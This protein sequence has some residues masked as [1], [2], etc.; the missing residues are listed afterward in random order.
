[1][2]DAIPI[3]RRPPVVPISD[4]LPA[5]LVRNLRTNPW[6]LRT[7]G[8][9]RQRQLHA[10]YDARRES[11][12]RAAD[13]AGLVYREADVA[14]RVAERLAARGCRPAARAAG[15]VHTLAFVPNLGWHFHLL[16][17]LRELGPVSLFDYTALG[18]TWTEFVRA[19]RHAIQRRARMNEQFLEYAQRVHAERPIDWLYVYASGLEVSASVIRRIGEELGVPTVS[20]CLDDKHAWAGPSMGDH[21]AGQIDIA[22]AFDLAWTSARVACEWYLVEGGNPIYLP[23]GFDAAA[24]HPMPV[25]VDLPASFVGTAYGFRPKVADYVRARGIPLRVFGAGWPYGEFARDPVEIFNRSVIN[26]GIGEAGYSE[27]LTNV[28]GRDFEIPGTGGGAYLTSYNADLAQ[29][30]VVGREILCYRSLDELVEQ[31][32]Y[33]LSH[34]DEAQAIAARAR[35]R[36]LREH[37]WLHRY[38]RVAQLLGVLAE[39]RSFVPSGDAPAVIAAD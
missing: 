20:M 13:Q 36:C 2:S 14:Q 28:K 30:F 4:A 10:Q 35:A 31:L 6:F 33:Y 29:H 26:V 21:R 11:Y 1:M 25:D 9:W 38:L 12:A 19:D 34:A 32:R 17:D 16:P 7:W 15:D 24:F 8:S 37:R 5:T 18:Y 22:G 23:E 39:D 27:S 3:S